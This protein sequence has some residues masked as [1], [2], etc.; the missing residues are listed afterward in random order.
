MEEAAADSGMAV[1]TEARKGSR[2]RLCRC[3]LGELCMTIRL[4]QPES[5]Q[6]TCVRVSSDPARARAV[7]ACPELQLKAARVEELIIMAC[8]DQ[9]PTNTR[10]KAKFV[11]G[12]RKPRD[13]RL[14]IGHFLNVDID[15]SSGSPKLRKE[16]RY[17]AH[18]VQPADGPQPAP[19]P[20]RPLAMHTAMLTTDARTKRSANREL[21]KR[22][23]ARA[24]E[25][26]MHPELF[27]NHE[28]LPATN[29][30]TKPSKR[31]RAP[32]TTTHP[33]VA[34]PPKKRVER[35]AQE[36][37][38]SSAFVVD[39]RSQLELIE[40][41]EAHAHA[42]KGRLFWATREM[43]THGVVGRMV[44]RCSLGVDCA[45]CSQEKSFRLA[46]S[47]S[48]VNPDGA[49]TVNGR[50]FVDYE[51]N[52]Q[53]AIAA[54]TTSV[55]TESFKSALM[56]M[57]L[58]PRSDAVTYAYQKQIVAPAVEAL[59]LAEQ[60]RAINDRPGRKDG[61]GGVMLVSHD[62]GHTGTNGQFSNGVG[63]DT[64]VRSCVC[65]T[66]CSYA[67]NYVYNCH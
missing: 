35:R 13:V 8:G 55:L 32:A 66:V 19:L 10:S 51:I 65:E 44:G 61:V 22:P 46:W 6:K 63:I 9:A 56:N 14:W 33:P 50:A 7:L 11:P 38:P 49:R 18:M 23:D 3:G 53:L 4:A 12:G 67:S 37:L 27:S 26:G 16:T 29:A 17:P 36:A 47:S 28:G 24:V 52:D 48:R 1:P 41:V 59:R 62:V 20:A 31:A 64:A 43:T 25:R 2:L 58:T 60:E 21:V 57:R 5:L 30:T 39:F 54:G 42:C 45:A 15:S 34:P 40:W